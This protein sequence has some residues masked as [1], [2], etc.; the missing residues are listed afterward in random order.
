MHERIATTLLERYGATPAD[1]SALRERLLW[2]MSRIGSP[3]FGRVFAAALGA[4][5]RA[6]VRLAAVRGIAGLVDPRISRTDGTT[7]PTSATTTPETEVLTPG[8]LIESLVAATRDA[9]P[10]VRRAAVDTIA[11]FGSNDT[12]VEALWNLLTPETEPEEAIRVAAWRGAMRMLASRPLD[13]IDAWLAKLPG[14]DSAKQQ[15]TLEL[16]QAA[17]SYLNGTA[18]KRGALGAARARLATARAQAGQ[19]DDAIALYMLAL[20]DLHTASSPALT[21]TAIDLLQLALTAGRYDETLA[22]ALASDNP[23]VDP[24]VLWDGV[25]P[26]LE[27]GITPE[28]VDATLRMLTQFQAHPPR[29]LPADRQQALEQMIARAQQVQ[30]EA[31]ANRVS[32]ALQALVANPQDEAASAALTQLGP[33]AVPHLRAALLTALQAEQPEAALVQRLHDLIKAIAPEWAGF[34]PDASID[35]KRKAIEALPG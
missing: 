25:A 18:A 6:E 20:D 9:D 28:G 30:R 31:D 15:H 11:G 13:V 17:E 23:G 8:A 2:A 21:Q 35:D 24:A 34:A 7:Q 16:L 14:D 1:Q 29:T 32:A 10:V 19:I 5:E 27:A 3:R 26:H 22:A 33:R 4:R 12:H